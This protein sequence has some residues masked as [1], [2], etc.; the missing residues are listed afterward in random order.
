MLCLA[1]ENACWNN[2]NG[3]LKKFR[4]NGKCKTIH[5]ALGLDINYCKNK[6]GINFGDYDVIIIDEFF[7]LP[8]KLMTLIYF[9]LMK[10]DGIKILIGDEKQNGYIIEKEKQNEIEKK[11]KSSVNN[12]GF[13]YQYSKCEFISDLI[14]FRYNK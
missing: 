2:M 11:Y 5:N 4:G 14:G 9:Q 6:D 8:Q 1:F 3:Y 13:K 7:R 10:F 12:K